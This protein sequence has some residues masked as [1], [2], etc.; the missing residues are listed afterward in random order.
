MNPDD[1]NNFKKI[2]DVLI[3]KLVKDDRVDYIIGIFENLLNNIEHENSFSVF[4]LLVHTN[5]VLD[6]PYLRTNIKLL[7][8]LI[9]IET[10]I[11]SIYN[12]ITKQ[13]I[14]DEIAIFKAK[15]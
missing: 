15:Y 6:Y 11:N 5:F 3:N 2:S 13:Q 1:I 14:L 4:S 8:M 7:E 12:N 10:K 9:Q